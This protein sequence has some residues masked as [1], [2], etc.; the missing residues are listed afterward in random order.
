MKL[1]R[2]TYKYKDSVINLILKGY[3]QLDAFKEFNIYANKFK[4]PINNKINIKIKE[5]RTVN[6]IW[7]KILNSMIKQEIY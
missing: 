7:I 4:L 2:F 6:N 3:D 5:L 1:F